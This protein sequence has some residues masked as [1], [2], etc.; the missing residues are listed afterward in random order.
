MNNEIFETMPVPKAYIRLALPVMMSSV[1]MLVYNMA[2]TYF[3]AA[4]GNTDIVAAVSLCAPVFTFLIAI[5]DILG[6]GG[7]S[8]ISRLLGS[9]R[10]TDAKRISVF[11]LCGSIVLGLAISL[12]LLAGK[13]VI[14]KLLGADVN[15]IGFAGEYYTWIALGASIIIF[16]LVPTNLL[17]TEGLAAKAMIGSMLGSVVNI[18]LD[19]VFISVLGM[20]A[21][22]A[23]IA[24]V[25]GNIFAD[26]YYIYVIMR[27]SKCLSIDPRGFR[28]S[29]TETKEVLHIGIPSS[30]TNIMQSI[31]VILL[32][33]FLLPYGNETIAA[34]GIVSK[35]TMI[36]I[37]IMVSFSF[38]GQPLYGY[39]YG[40][41][42]RNRFREVMHFAYRLVCGL[43]IAISCV[44]FISAPFLVGLFINDASFV[45]LGASMLRTI[46]P[47][48]PFIGFTMVTTCIFQSTG[49]ANGALALSAGRQGYIYAAVLFVL[50]AL[51]GYRGVISA[52]PAA[53]ALS[54]LLAFFLLRKLLKDWI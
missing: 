36:V 35:I 8:F 54:S 30:I 25:I 10:N 46:L 19:P 5:G 13:P 28:I 11:C 6:L 2:D 15:T 47:G 33:N 18:I 23:A 24:T 38:G 17:R 1:L 44:L 31:G 52:Q 26:I 21:A 40:A 51:F 27:H 48:M 12:I 7:S 29:H 14:L 53:D 4:T 3:I 45:E 43:G 16:S 49:K 39:L 37:M 32:N 20:G 42:N 34:M 22:G 9:G 41:G 50:S